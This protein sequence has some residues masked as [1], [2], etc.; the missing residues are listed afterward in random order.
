M[1]GRVA[2][3]G[4]LALCLLA[5]AARDHRI[6]AGSS[7]RVER[8]LSS[9][10]LEEKISLLHGVLEDP[11]TDQGEAGYLPGIPRL[12][13][14]P[15]RLADGP[16]GV[17]TRYPATALTATMG[18]AA[19]FSPEDA[20]AN[21]VV[22][23]RDARNL[24]IDVVLQPYINMDRDPTFARA[25]NTYGED[26]LLTGTMGAALIRGI[27]GEGIM[28]QAKH[29]IGYDGANDVTLDAQT[30]HE[31]YLAPFEAAVQ[32]RVASIMCSYN[33][34]N[35]AYA[36][37]NRALLTGVLRDELKF[38]GFV[39]S[40]WGAVHATSFLEAGDDLEMPGSGS[41]TDCYFE[42]QLPRPGSFRK[43]L[44]GPEINPIPEEYAPDGRPFVVTVP[45]ERP[46]GVLNALARGNLSEEALTR[47]ARD[48]LVQ[49][50]RFGVLDRK[51]AA[52]A[53]GTQSEHAGAASAA[54]VLKTSEDAAVLLKNSPDALPLT[55]ADLSSLALIGP[56]ALQDIAA[57]E[58]GEKALGH[59]ERQI[60]PAAAMLKLAG[61]SAVPAV[62]IE[63]AAADDMDGVTV[64]VGFQRLDDAGQAIG[65][66]AQLDFTRVRGNALPAGSSFSWTGTLQIPAS[67][68][69]RL[70]LQVLGASATM[71]VDGKAFAHSG[72]LDLHGNLLQPGQDNVLPSRD[73]L[74]DVR[75]EITFD[76][77]PHPV[78]VQVKAQA[79]G[80][81]V[82]VRL[83]WVTPQQR[84]ADYEHAIDVAA[85]SRKAVVFAWSRGRPVFHLPG[86]QDQLIA[87]VAAVNPNTIVVLNLSAPVTMPWLDKV[88]AVLLM[89]Y[90]GDEGGPA[91]ANLLLGR[92]SPAGRLPFT[93]PQTLEQG[94]ANDPAHPERS[95]VG[96][97]GRTQ[98]SE[99]IFI[100][101]RWFD[102][103]AISPLY[104][105][106][107]GL[108]YTRF[109]Y[110]DL[111]VHPAA[112][113]GLDVSLQL[114]NSGSLA[115]D[116]VV[117]AYLGAPKQT[118]SDAQFAP[119][120]LGAFDRVHLASGESRRVTL[121]MEARALQY[122]STAR[123][124][125]TTAPGA[126][127]VYVGASSRDLRLN[128]ETIIPPP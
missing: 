114:R 52:A 125:W 56:G 34:I 98:Y 31:I 33:V 94:V 67:G 68:R 69:Y 23:A 88:K 87:D 45:M 59:L 14:P 13:I 96:I 5:C 116:E 104:P 111:R 60:G 72:A 128:M 99:G 8:L 36:C 21:G 2:V 7:M 58:S 121:H 107:F 40:D 16:P 48:I 41:T 30:L 106:G 70:Y 17:L 113:G 79:G 82:Q 51:G 78:T 89:W 91:T 73:G 83:A 38:D 115:G 65:Q 86:D 57:G 101:Y 95:S 49:M 19:T 102:Q 127:T 61:G 42:A 100:G 123:A 66:D 64:P 35:G 63:A 97:N 29:F 24:G 1:I 18:L 53:S 10:T 55:G 27:Q 32:A 74:D 124:R 109:E 85:R 76:A 71:T 75:R 11:A 122:W 103:Q 54:I 84:R 118:M 20:R 4:A 3:P 112:D 90:P 92:V 9:M 80:Q 117:Q 120:S 15:L 93:W 81:P 50:Q 12:G 28:A 108:S 47:A 44:L 77:G 37:G 43:Q 46:M 110:S 26:P 39:T 62:H 126:R 119:R 25:Y 105:F 6:P 22:I